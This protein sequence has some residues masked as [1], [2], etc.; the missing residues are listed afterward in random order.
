MKQVK[1][2]N[3]LISLSVIMILLF[4]ILC[5]SLSVKG[6]NLSFDFENQTYGW[7]SLYGGSQSEFMTEDTGNTYLKLN[8]VEGGE[9]KYF[10]IS[11]VSH[12]YIGNSKRIQINY[13]VMYP[14]FTETRDGEMH[15][16]NRIGP[17]SA[18]TTM[19]ARVAQVNGYFQVQG[20]EGQGFQRI[21]GMNGQ[22]FQMETGHWYT[23][24][25]IV[26]LDKHTQYTYIFDRDTENLI[27]IHQ[28]ISTINDTVTP[29]MVSFSSST[30]IC[31]DNVRIFE[32]SC[33]GG[34]IYG[35]PYLKR[36]N[37]ETYYYLAN[38]SDGSATEWT[39]GTTKWSIENSKTGVSI[40][41]NS[42]RVTTYSSVEPG[43]L[44]IKAERTINDTVYESKFAVNITD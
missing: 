14:E 29:N 23:V 25:M 20:G 31:L 10:D 1:R 36:G 32:P 27:A 30:S 15:I 17:G 37:K 13:D 16:K 6:E 28:E 11:A 39:Q 43:Y 34:R 40:D 41:E 2:K 4:S 12:L 21:K 42:G 3:K 44:I 5:Y 24:K 38:N 26:D 9:R 22:Y 35:A 18:E 8:F 19:V 33:E 7:D